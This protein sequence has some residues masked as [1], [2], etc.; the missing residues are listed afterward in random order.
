MTKSERLL[1]IEIDETILKNG[2]AGIKNGQ[3]VDMRGVDGA[4]KMTPNTCLNSL[5]NLEKER[6]ELENE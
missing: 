3:L 5:S 6:K 1:S 4:V 2:F